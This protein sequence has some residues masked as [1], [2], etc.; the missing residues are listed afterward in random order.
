MKRASAYKRRDGW[1]IHADSTTEVGIWMATPPYIKLDSDASLEAVG[2]AVLDALAASQQGVPHPPFN[3]LDDKFDPK[4]KLAGVKTWA[5][6]AKR[7]LCVGIT[8]DSQWLTVEPWEN[9]GAK[10]GFVQMHGLEMRI[11]ARSPPA[12]IGAAIEKAFTLC[13]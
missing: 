8:S 3:E 11:P 4:L 10:D 6:F 2:R 13:L 7:T 1:Y 9:K 12:Q 5:T